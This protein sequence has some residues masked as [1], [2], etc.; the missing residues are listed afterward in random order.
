M[1]T[2]D[3]DA[4]NFF[5]MQTKPPNAVFLEVYLGA[6]D[7]FLFVELN[8]AIELQGNHITDKLFRIL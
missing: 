1:R 3:M 2:L 6:I 4:G 5:D 8:D 7:M